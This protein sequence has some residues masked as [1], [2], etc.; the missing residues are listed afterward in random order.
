MRQRGDGGD[1][2]LDECERPVLE[3]RGWIGLGMDVGDLLELLRALQGDGIGGA[4]PDVEGAGASREAK[5]ERL[6]VRLGR[7]RGLDVGRQALHSLD[8]PPPLLGREIAGAAELQR[9]QRER[10]Q[11][12]RVGLGRRHRHLRARVHVDSAVGFAGDA[13][14][15][16]VD[17]A[18]HPAAAA[19]HL[20][21]RHQRVDGLARLADRDVER[22]ALDD[23]VA[24]AELGRGLGRGRDAREGFDEVRARDARVVRGAAA[25]ELDPLHVEQLARLEVEPAEVCGMEL[26]IEPS[27]SVRSIASG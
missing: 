6:H 13:A 4:A 7:E 14:A 2:R 24:I 3:L 11:A 10:D 20:L 23:G 8:E 21:H 27:P 19:A 1:A 26:T 15:D 5:R 25:E 22:V 16:H 12:A 17:D 9:E 18:E